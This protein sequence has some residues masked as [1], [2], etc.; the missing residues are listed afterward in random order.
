MTIR[1]TKIT[2]IKIF[3]KLMLPSVMRIGISRDTHIVLEGK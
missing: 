2:I 3:K 1:I